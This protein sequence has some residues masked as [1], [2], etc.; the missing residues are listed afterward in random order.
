MRKAL[1]VFLLG[2]TLLIAACQKPVQQD[3]TSFEQCVAAGNPVMESHPRQCRAD[4]KLFVEEIKEQKPIE[5]V[6]CS[7]GQQEAQ[8]CTKEYRPVCALVDNNIRCITTPCASTDAATYGNK[9]EAC[10]AKAYGYYQGACGEVQFV[11]CPERPVGFDP[12]EYARNNNGAC[13]DICP[14]NYDGFMTRIG[15]ELCIKHYG[16]EEIE[17]WKTCGRSS[18]SCECVKAYETTSGQQVPNAQFRCVPELYAQRLLFRG[19]VEQL[20]ENGKSSSAIA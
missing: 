20:D 17:Q 10:S 7:E 4:G 12:V 14:G 16:I 9:C 8:A 3:I 19:G 1:L 5:L 18:E 6:Q 11:I 2:L 13:V 15:V